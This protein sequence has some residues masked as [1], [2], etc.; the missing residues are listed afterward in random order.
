MTTVQGLIVD[1]I[2]AEMRTAPRWLVWRRVDGRKI[3]FDVRTS[4]ACDPTD[5]ASWSTFEDAVGASPHYDGLGFALGKDGFEFWSGVDLDNC[6]QKDGT[7]TPAAL[8]IVQGLNSYTEES[9]SG[10]GLHVLTK[11]P[12]GG[13]YTRAGLEV[14]DEKR[15]FV[16]TGKHVPGTP[17]T[18]EL[19]AIELADL[20]KREF[21]ETQAPRKAKATLPAAIGD[22]IRNDQLFEEACR[23]RQ[24]GHSATEILALLTAMNAERVHPPLPASEVEQI[25]H[26]ATRYEPGGSEFHRYQSGNRKD[27]IIADDQ[28]N[29][30]LALDSLGFVLRYNEFADVT[31]VGADRDGI[32]RERPLDDALLHAMWLGIDRRFQF[33][34]SLE[35]FT[36]VVRDR[37]RYTR[38]HP[39]KDYLAGLTWDGHPRLDT[40]L[41]TYASAENSEYVRAVA[42]RTL[43]AAVRRVRIPGVKFDELLILESPVQGTEKSSALRA[44]C[45][46]DEYFSDDLPL[47][48]DSK[49]VIER[50]AGKW[51]IEASELHGYSNA[52]ND[53]LKSF[54]SRQTDGPVR[55]AYARTS[56]EVR[57]Q[58]VTIGTTNEVTDYLRD[59]TGNRRFWPVRIQRF[60]VTAIRRDRDQLWAEA[61]VREESGESIRLPEALW[62]V[63][64]VEQ[65]ARR[66]I[67]PWEEL[68]DDAIDF[69]Q[70]AV[71]VSELW[72][73]LGEAGRYYKR[74]DAERLARIMQRRRFT[75]RKKAFVTYVTNGR[76]QHGDDRKWAWIKEGTDPGRVRIRRGETEL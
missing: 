47:G 56:V 50:T 53:R 4:K 28:Q 10:D 46:D 2:P 58:F 64:A 52:Q 62:S 39:V 60:D 3:P 24:R 23:L 30:R 13:N 1:A 22:G 40:W 14:Y 57:R 63:A 59:T 21:P 31:L 69:D 19:R 75:R 67:D 66:A 43:I 25:A 32:F 17:T 74:N 20:I 6:R 55:L 27:Q 37:A 54:L 45:P 44:L 8:T 73:A 26:S 70:E 12:T 29:V 51:I 16:V 34:P 7:F 68:L 15:Y 42:S 72:V 48:V 61:V 41:T 11:G 9:V 71:A 35:F 36:I 49:Q 76:E 33:R 5:P 65:E 18:V 38:F